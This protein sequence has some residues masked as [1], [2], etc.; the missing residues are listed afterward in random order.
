MHSNMDNTME[1]II[2]NLKNNIGDIFYQ[3]KLVKNKNNINVK[4]FKIMNFECLLLYV[5]VSKSCLYSFSK[6]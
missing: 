1:K 6:I 3:H 4:L 2:A 5:F